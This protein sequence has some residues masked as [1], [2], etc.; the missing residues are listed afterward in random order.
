M[1]N[2]KICHLKADLSNHIV[3]NSCGT[4]IITHIVDN[5]VEK[6]V[7]STKDIR[8]RFNLYDHRNKNILYVDILIT[9]NLELMNS[10]E[11]VLVHTLKPATNTVKYE[12][13]N[14]D[15]ELMEEL[16]ENEIY[17]RLNE[18]E[19]RIGYRY[20]KYVT[21]LNKESTPKII[22][23]KKD[24]IKKIQKTKTY[25]RVPLPKTIEWDDGDVVKFDILDENTVSMR[26]VLKVK[27]VM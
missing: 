25:Q 23:E 16:L 27:D 14:K 8:N 11:R 19:F 6:Y 18:K 7:G 24:L 20:L 2:L 26:R 10:L 13:T 9:E 15:K 12:L 5:H 3:S 4:Y 17:E 22:D 21:T 1:N